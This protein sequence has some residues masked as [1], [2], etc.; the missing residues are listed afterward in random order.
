MSF[1][2]SHLVNMFNTTFFFKMTE[3]VCNKYKL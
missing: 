3:F 1:Y 2:K